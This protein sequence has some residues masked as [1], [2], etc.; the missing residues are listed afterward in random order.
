MERGERGEAE[1][2]KHKQKAEARHRKEIGRRSR[3]EG[4]HREFEIERILFWFWLCDLAGGGRRAAL[5]M[6]KSLTCNC[7]NNGDVGGRRGK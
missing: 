5:A 4:S 6:P 1:K 2:E 7:I 3:E